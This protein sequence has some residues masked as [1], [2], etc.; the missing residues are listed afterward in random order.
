MFPFEDNGDV[1]VSDYVVIPKALWEHSIEVAAAFTSPDTPLNRDCFYVAVVHD[2]IEDGLCTLEDLEK[3]GASKEVLEAVD[4]I[5]RR[6]DEVYSDYISRCKQ[7]KIARM[8]KLEDL[9]VNIKRC[10]ADLPDR[11]SLLER[12][13]KAYRKLQ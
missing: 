8:V 2:L 13:V 3:A 7:N 5:T 1:R 9:K 11:L 4:Y 10:A 12:Y 6:E